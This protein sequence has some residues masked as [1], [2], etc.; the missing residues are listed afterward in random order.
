M[1]KINVH[2]GSPIKRAIDGMVWWSEERAFGGWRRLRRAVNRHR[3]QQRRFRRAQKQL[4]KHEYQ[5]WLEQQK[6]EYVI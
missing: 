3:R 1:R 6:R 2:V 4:K 5:M